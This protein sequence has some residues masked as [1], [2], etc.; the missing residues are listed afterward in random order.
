MVKISKRFNKDTLLRFIDILKA[1]TRGDWECA[2]ILITQ[3]EETELASFI[4]LLEIKADS[5]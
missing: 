5:R 1:G 2:D 4:D 3:L